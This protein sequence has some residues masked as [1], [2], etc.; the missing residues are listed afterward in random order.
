MER[1]DKPPY[2]R[3]QVVGVGLV[4]PDEGSV[5]IGMRSPARCETVFS[6]RLVVASSGNRRVV[7]GR[8]VGQ[9][10]AYCGRDPVCQAAVTTGYG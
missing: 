2:D 7:T 1:A 6:H 9:T 4:A 3:G 5:V 8:H 10:T